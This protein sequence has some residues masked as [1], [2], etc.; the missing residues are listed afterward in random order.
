LASVLL[1]TSRLAS[2]AVPAGHSVRAAQPPRPAP[3]RPDRSGRGD[4]R[5]ASR[6]A[7][8][9]SRSGRL[10]ASMHSGRLSDRGIPVGRIPRIARRGRSAAVN[11]APRA[12]RESHRLRG[13]PESVEPPDR[14]PGS[15]IERPRSMSTLRVVASPE[16]GPY[17]QHSHGPRSKKISDQSPVSIFRSNIRRPG[18][19]RALACAIAAAG[20]FSY[21]TSA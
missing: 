17:W 11:R 19:L 18:S 2:K 7:G 1:C 15:N 20:L 14:D 10:A 13:G 5:N 9:S 8:A 12:V 6:V 4:R 3:V 21:F 16:D